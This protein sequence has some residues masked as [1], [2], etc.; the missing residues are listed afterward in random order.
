MTCVLPAAVVCACL[1]FT[2][3]PPKGGSYKSKKPVAS[4][5]RRNWNAEFRRSRRMMGTL[6]EIQ[7][8]HSNAEAASAAMTAAARMCIEIA[9]MK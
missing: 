4:A 2:P 6:C 8:Y 5:F 3:V 1:A 7:V 9:T